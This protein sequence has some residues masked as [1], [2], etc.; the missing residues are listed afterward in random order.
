MHFDAMSEGTRFTET[1]FDRQWHELRELF[2]GAAPVTNKNHY[3]RWE[4]DCEFFRWCA[5]RGI[6]LDQ[7]KGASKPGEAG[8][9]FGTCHPYFPVEIDGRSIDVLELTTPTQDLNV[10]APEP[11][12]RPLLESVRRRHGILH[13]LFHPTHTIRDD[14]AGALERSVALA[15]E[16]GMEWWI[17]A[18]IN[19]WERARRKVRWSDY[20]ASKSGASVKLFVVDE[21]TDAT[22]LWLA[23]E[24]AAATVQR[25]GFD[26]RPTVMSL[27]TDS[28]SH[29]KYPD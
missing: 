24:P 8:F 20:H 5:A 9:N 13:L 28:T 19:A 16:R 3:L 7:S 2:G 6:Q 1:E 29:F 18:D 4:G 21:L 25:W 11:L 15:R 12:F 10:F 17:A 27:S 22:I 26:F 14:V 23:S